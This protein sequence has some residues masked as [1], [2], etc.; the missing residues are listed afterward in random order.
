MDEAVS[1]KPQNLETLRRKLADWFARE[2]RDLPWR[3][4]D[5]PYAIMVS[6]FMLQQTTVNAVIPYFE[7]WMKRLPTVRA[8]AHA[9]EQEVLALWQGLGY[10][11]RARNLHK[12]AKAIMAEHGG[13]IPRSAADLRK[14]PGVGA[15]TAAAVA[16]F[17]F[18]AVEPVVDANIARVLARLHG[19][20]KPIDDTAG[21]V[22]L[23]NAAR[24]LLPEKGG[25]LHNSALMELGALVCVARTPHC[26]A[27]PVRGECQARYPERLPIKRIRKKIEEVA[28]TRA[29]IVQEGKLWLAP[30]DGPRWHGMWVLPLTEA[31]DREPDHI[32]IH[33]I[34]RFRV[35]MQLFSEPR[36]GR[37]LTG[38]ALEALPPM[39]SPHV[40]AVAAML[41]K[42]H[43]V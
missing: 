13:K 15:Y 6:E 35:T 14:L 24:D 42:L 11:S 36:L 4:T 38:F 27:C 17:A 26:L 9:D 18:D 32:E 23:E 20:E 12:A 29:Y 21:K 2:G 43:T 19:W 25:R 16:A 5:D 37:P 7:R 30:S 40:R 28:E 39:P 1:L 31:N 41:E 3:R 33:P 10:Y 22:F 34:T 8:L